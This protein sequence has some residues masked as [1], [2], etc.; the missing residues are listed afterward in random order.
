MKINAKQVSLS[1]KRILRGSR[2]KL[3]SCHAKI[4]KQNKTEMHAFTK[5]PVS[6]I[7]K[8]K[9]LSLTAGRSNIDKLERRVGSEQTTKERQEHL[10]PS[11]RTQVECTGLQYV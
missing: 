2:T 4:L 3:V 9:R 1:T 11:R 6:L 10:R 7:T 8:L 5:T